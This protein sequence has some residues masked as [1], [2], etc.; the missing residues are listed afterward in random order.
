MKPNVEMSMLKS[1]LE[2]SRSSFPMVYHEFFLL[3][4]GASAKED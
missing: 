3:R 2:K 1:E 4:N